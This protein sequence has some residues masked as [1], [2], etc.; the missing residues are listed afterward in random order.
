MSATYSALGTMVDVCWDLLMIVN[1]DG[2][3]Q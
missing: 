3:L 2:P 1:P